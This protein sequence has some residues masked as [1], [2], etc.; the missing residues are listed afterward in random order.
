MLVLIDD[1][2]QAPRYPP[3]PASLLLNAYRGPSF[4][5]ADDCE[6][7]TFAA[8]EL[9]CKK[10]TVVLEDFDQHG[11]EMFEQIAKLKSR[12]GKI[13][14]RIFPSNL[15]SPKFWCDTTR[16]SSRGETWP[17]LRH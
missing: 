12:F 11:L 10:S 14:A 13:T 9:A 17:L 7:V 6:E 3:A 4:I 1:T 2:D 15:V 16:V 8:V 5:Q